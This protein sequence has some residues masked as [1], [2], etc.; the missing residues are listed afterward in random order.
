MCGSGALVIWLLYAAAVAFWGGKGLG[1]MQEGPGRKA[2]LVVL[3]LLLLLPLIGFKWG[4]LL[5]NR[6][7]GTQGFLTFA[8]PMG[9]SFYTLAM[10]GYCVDIYRNECCA[11]TNFWRILLFCTF[12]PQIVQGPIARYPVLRETLIENRNL[13]MW[14]SVMDVS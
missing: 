2:F 5:E 1:S 14:I 11:E 12:F 4:A 7:S 13:T 10:I 3:V 6:L 9:I 8:V